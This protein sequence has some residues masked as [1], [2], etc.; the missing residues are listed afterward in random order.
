LQDIN[1]DWRE[2]DR[3]EFAKCV[4][5]AIEFGRHVMPTKPWPS[6]RCWA[7]P[8]R[9]HLPACMETPT[10]KAPLV[11]RHGPIAQGKIQPIRNREFN[12]LT[13]SYFTNEV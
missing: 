4:F 8:P 11:V 10:R 7:P 9:T 13:N 5:Q 2:V 12:P 3:R 1:D 6:F